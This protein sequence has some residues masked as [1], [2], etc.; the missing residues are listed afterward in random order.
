MCSF[1]EAPITKH[2]LTLEVLPL[3]FVV[4]NVPTLASFNLFRAEN[5]ICR[6]SDL[7]TQR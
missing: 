7:L 4:C 6:T 3:V 5:R 2:N 1:A